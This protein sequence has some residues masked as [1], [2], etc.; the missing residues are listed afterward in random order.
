MALC[1][2]GPAGCEDGAACAD[3]RFSGVYCCRASSQH[4]KDV[5]PAMASVIF[6]CPVEF[7][8]ISPAFHQGNIMSREVPTAMKENTTSENIVI[9]IKIER[10]KLWSRRTLEAATW[11]ICLGLLAAG[12]AFAACAA[13]AWL[14][15]GSEA[16]L[17]LG[18]GGGLLLGLAGVWHL[19]H[20][21]DRAV[22][23]LRCETPGAV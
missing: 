19:L 2:S 22:R 5:N 14:V 18:L 21:L 13:L 15:T 6:H 16:M 20:R 4:F 9:P 17:A 23:Q 11:L 12:G 1:S 10:V 8:V 7:T 3:E